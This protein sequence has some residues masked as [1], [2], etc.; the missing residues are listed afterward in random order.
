M[1]KNNEPWVQRS[2]GEA[3]RARSSN[4]KRLL[5]REGD[6]DVNHSKQFLKAALAGSFVD[7]LLNIATNT[8]HLKMLMS[9]FC[10]ADA[11]NENVYS[12]L[13]KIGQGFLSTG[14]NKVFVHQ[15]C[16]EIYKSGI[17]TRI[18]PCV[19]SLSP[20]SSA[21]LA[22]LVATL[23]GASTTVRED[24]T[25]IALANSLKV[26]YPHLAT[27]L[28]PS[29]LESYTTTSAVLS[30]EDV[31]LLQPLH[32]NDH[33]YDF[34]KIDVLPTV[35]ELMCNKSRVMNGPRSVLLSSQMSGV[36]ALLDRQF[37][38]LRED[39]L[40]PLKQE[41]WGVM[42][43]ASPASAQAKSS[44]LPTPSSKNQARNLHL[45]VSIQGVQANYNQM[46]LQIKVGINSILKSQLQGCK[47]N[48]DVK[49][50][51]ESKRGSRILSRNS[52]VI[53]MCA[54][55]KPL[56][57]AIVAQRQITDNFVASA[58]KGFLEVGVSL[59]NKD[60][61]QSLQNAQS[62]SPS[63][64]CASFLYCS[65]ASFF[66]YEAVLMRLQAMIDIPFEEEIVHNQHPLR[67]EQQIVISKKVKKIMSRD[68]FQW[69]ALQ[70]ACRDRL[71]I[72]QGPPGTGK[73]FI[74]VHIAK[75]LLD[76]DPS[77]KI[78]CVTFTN[79][80]VDSFVSD[81]IDAGV[82]VS[83]IKRLGYSNKI[84][85]KIKPCCLGRG[86]DRPVLPHNK[87]QHLKQWRKEQKDVVAEAGMIYQKLSN[88]KTWDERSWEQFE[89]YLSESDEEALVHQLRNSV[90]VDGTVVG[91]KGKRRSADYTFCQWYRGGKLP[92]SSEY[93]DADLWTMSKGERQSLVQFYCTEYYDELIHNLCD[94]FTLSQTIYDNI[95]AL[96]QEEK[97]TEIKS[98]RILSCTT[99]GAASYHDLISDYQPTALIIEEAAE[100]LEAHVLVNLTHSLKQVIMIGDHKQLRPKLEMY[101]FR[102]AS[103]RGVNFDVSLFE[104]LVVNASIPK[105]VLQTQHRMRPEI[106]EIVR[107][108]TYP[109]LVDAEQ[110]KGRSDIKGLSGNVVF[111]NHLQLEDSMEATN[112]T[113]SYEAEMVVQTVVYLLQQGYESSDIVILTPYLGQMMHIIN[114]LS[115]TKNI[116]ARIGV[117]DEDELEGCSDD[118]EVGNV[119]TSLE[120]AAGNSEIKS[121][122]VATVDNFQGEEAKIIV[123]SLV[124]SDTN[125]FSA[126]GKKGNIGFLCE[127]E[128][129]NV[130]F[131]RARDGLIVFGNVLTLENS[132]ASVLWKSIINYFRQ[133]N[134]LYN[135]L[136][137]KCAN[138][139][140]LALLQKPEDFEEFCPSGKF[141]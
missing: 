51:F 50:F 53:F 24:P 27:V 77:A 87:Y 45:G 134:F 2:R 26:S 9:V 121:I 100:I 135:G 120:T 115:K 129:V 106:S 72:I 35:D 104:R 136:P 62:A 116:I 94:M 47:T 131:S 133:R 30:V 109:E 91:K 125:T 65:S 118:I 44:G 60:L 141:N 12:F 42:Q 97:I 29:E 86:E 37:R 111:V 123:A 68:S 132:K 23:L 98:A 41:L 90:D 6:S 139:S 13:D 17:L 64:E 15:C 99:S 49:H 20:Q 128:R 92:S 102:K 4:L 8:K 80:A 66:A 76:N 46:H 93:A 127:P 138:H 22:W 14:H 105:S 89:K 61:F 122:R 7:N 5:E 1:S 81:I 110:V 57:V 32:S 36:G 126:N 96:E 73:T 140:C 75:T 34:R 107:R 117:L 88:H 113:N 11:R 25:V 84:A 108:T 54:E 74:G 130:L 112:H 69:E 67:I 19:S 56:G 39:M 137:T 59:P 79:H 43:E 33:P 10:F 114:V 63:Q 40:Q 21:P 18:R 83:Q 101:E 31:E 82:D 28:F 16:M 124:R 48:K 85:D 58:R 71:C 70:K 103:N 95:T 119:W 52:I 78:L 3:P 55:R 38:F